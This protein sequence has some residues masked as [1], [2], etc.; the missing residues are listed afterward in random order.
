MSYKLTS[1]DNAHLQF[2][3]QQLI[4]QGFDHFRKDHTVTYDNV[5]KREGRKLE[6]YNQH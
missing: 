3:K 5:K 2:I 4:D 6:K 1:N